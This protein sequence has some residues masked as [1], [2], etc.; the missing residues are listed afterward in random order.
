M[1]FMALKSFF[2]MRTVI[3]ILVTNRLTPKYGPQNDDVSTKKEC[4]KQEWD[5]S[6]EGGMS[7]L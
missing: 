5:L 2:K 6:W 7:K 1:R 4:R 3:L